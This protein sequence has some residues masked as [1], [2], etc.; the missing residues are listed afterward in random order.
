MVNIANDLY[1]KNRNENL[2]ISGGSGMNSVANGILMEK[3]QYNKIYIPPAPGDAG[4]SLGSAA[5]QINLTKEKPLQFNDN[6]YLGP[7]YSNQEIKNEIHAECDK[8]NKNIY[9]M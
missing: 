6:P 7:S 1:E 3:T 9:L 2:C 5:F 8:D 4:G